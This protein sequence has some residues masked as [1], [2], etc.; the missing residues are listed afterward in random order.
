MKLCHNDSW[1][2]LTLSYDF[3]A[4]LTIST[5]MDVYANFTLNNYTSLVE[6]P[7]TTQSYGVVQ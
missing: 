3:V 2:R 7:D 1:L 5:C 4:K 6:G